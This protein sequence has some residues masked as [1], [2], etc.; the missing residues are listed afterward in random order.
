V[1]KGLV[2]TRKLL[3]HLLERLES[4]ESA[5]DLLDIAHGRAVSAT[6]A[7]GMKGKEKGKVGRLGQ[8]MVAAA[9]S[10]IGV[11]QHP[12]PSNQG[13]GDGS[14]EEGEVEKGHARNKWD[15]EQTYDLVDQTRGLL[16][17]AHRQGLNL[18]SEDVELG[19]STEEYLPTP[20]KPRKLG[21][22]LS[23]FTSPIAS[24]KPAFP[25]PPRISIEE[26]T[27]SSTADKSLRERLLDLL[28]N[29]MT[30]DGLHQI[31][32]F[33][34]VAPP[35]ALQAACLDIAS[36][37]YNISDLD[38]QIRLLEVVIGSLS[39]MASAS[40][41]R[42]CQWLEGRLGHV[43]ETLERERQKFGTQQSL[44][45]TLSLLHNTPEHIVRLGALVPNAIVALASTIQSSIT[46]LSAS[47]RAHRILSMLLVTKPDCALDLLQVIAFSSRPARRTALS[48]LNTYYPSLMGHN[49][50][51]RRFPELIY[52]EHRK[53]VEG[54]ITES[55]ESSENHTY[56][57]WRISSKDPIPPL[58]NR[59]LTCEAEI[60]GFCV[61]C[62]LCTDLRH[63]Q[64]IQTPNEMMT[65]DVIRMST[66]KTQTVHVKYSRYLA[67]LD[68]K[69]LNG[70]TPRGTINSTRRL[71]GQHELHLVNL[72]SLTN[73]EGCREPLWGTLAQA[74]A[75]T[76]GCQRFYHPACVDRLH[77]TAN[78]V[79]RPGQHV[80][81]D[82]ITNN[83][84][85]PFR[86]TGQTL[87][88]SSDR[89]LAPFCHS[90]NDLADKTYDELAVM[91]GHL[92]AQQKIL[93]TGLATGTIYI[94]ERDKSR[95]RSDPLCLRSFIRSY[96]E[97]LASN[98]STASPAAAD[99]AHVNNLSRPF[100]Q[101][102]L[103]SRGFLTYC[104]ALIR[105]PPTIENHDLLNPFG[106]HPENAKS[107]NTGA[108]EML[109]L[110]I[111][112]SSLAH[113]L[114]IHDT[115]LARVLLNQLNALGLCTIIQ[116]PRVEDD[117]VREGDKWMSFG[118]P[119]LMV[120]TPSVEILITAI[121]VLLDDVDL[122]F[123]EQAMILLNTLAW[124]SLLCSPYALERISG[125][126]AAWVMHEVSGLEV[127][128]ATLLTT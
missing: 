86:I 29:L 7:A 54:H 70:T 16:V 13:C 21:A 27:D 26:L 58:H 92:W 6:W 108:A 42:I 30:Q 88:A 56:I 57:P 9:Q 34:L 32:R 14:D 100:G 19:R 96:E 40:T 89:H 73:C 77:G 35:K 111:I 95:S 31:H 104:T 3:A 109:S 91:Y 90:E 17:L 71:V 64:C 44:L 45:S 22:R 69:V 125:A 1:P 15:T 94:I 93:E 99:F 41:E 23:S 107:D 113:D 55:A 120:A 25:D 11:G 85:D 80:V 81:I 2:E 46:S 75:C 115:N 128:R 122:S 83:S 49:V 62:S 76:N 47:Y 59:C 74:Y 78:A 105:S 101:G 48:L 106:N 116:Q 63:I 4:R 114:A 52:S 8:V 36:V 20:T 112:K 24:Q 79:C 43:L 60:H 50:V 102:Y 53:S 72:F 51:A 110:G 65:Y 127:A 28:Q 123:N 37:M 10:G 39:Y 87:Q 18:F 5:P 117:D 126:V 84:S 68:E 97:Y 82:D 118:L 61:K 124:A 38:D 67:R 66:S 98:F 121:E 12:S 103:F 33:R 119:L